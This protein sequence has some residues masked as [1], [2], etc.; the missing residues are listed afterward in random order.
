MVDKLVAKRNTLTDQEVIFIVDFFIDVCKHYQ[1]KDQHALTL[2]VNLLPDFFKRAKAHHEE[3]VKRALVEGNSELLIVNFALRSKELINKI[4]YSTDAKNLSDDQFEMLFAIT[5]EEL[6]DP[7]T[8]RSGADM[9]VYTAWF[10][11]ILI[12]TMQ[13]CSK[14]F[15]TSSIKS[16]IEKLI[17]KNR[18]LE[19][20]TNSLPMLIVVQMYFMRYSEERD[21]TI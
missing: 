21:N 12:K 15:D 17:V 11:K 9:S 20:A 1:L 2:G 16:S 13:Y 8:S 18:R 14:T 6:K 10:L 19:I 4:R 3:V 7:K 5:H